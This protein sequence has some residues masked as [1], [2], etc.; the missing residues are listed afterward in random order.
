MASANI[1]LKG[2]GLV[3]EAVAAAASI[4]PGH[5]LDLTINSG[6]VEV[7]VGGAATALDAGRAAFAIE[8][9]EIGNEVTDAYA[10]NDTVKYVV[11]HRGDEVQAR[12][13]VS[14][15]WAAGAPLYA[16]AAGRVTDVPGSGVQALGYALTAVSSSTADLL[17]DMEVA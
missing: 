6:V 17:V 2:S 5:R 16:A 8:A 3:K 15:T 1:H 4:L 9:S 13:V 12:A 11:A 10:D 7:G 14:L